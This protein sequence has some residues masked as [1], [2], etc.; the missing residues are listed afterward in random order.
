MS[1]IESAQYSKYKDTIIL[2]FLTD[3]YDL[4][5]AKQI[6][7]Q[8]VN[9]FPDNNILCLPGDVSIAILREENPFL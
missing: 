6:Y 1:K 3:E 5:K 7:K 4:D 2:Q 9:F 8:M